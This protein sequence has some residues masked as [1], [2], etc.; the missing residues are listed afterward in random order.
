MTHF[1]TGDLVKANTTI[2]T[3][4]TDR[5]GGTGLS[6]GSVGVVTATMGRRMRVDFKD[7][8]WGHVT[9]SSVPMRSCHLV[10]RNYG[11][12]TFH[13]SRRRTRPIRMGIALFSAMPFMWF[14]IQFFLTNGL[15]L[16][17]FVP[18]LVGSCVDSVVQFIEWGITAPLQT[19]ALL[20]FFALIGW[21]AKR[22]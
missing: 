18:A 8:L 21:V 1:R 12:D 9:A 19:A 10:R 22:V 5:L 11:V 6:R 17:G 3:N 4:F 20:G 16:H 7:S 2:A 15:T 13:R 14:A